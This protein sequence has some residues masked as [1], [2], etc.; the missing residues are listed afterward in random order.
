VSELLV[1]AHEDVKL[2]LAMDDCIELMAE[3]LADLARGQSWQ[4]LRFVVRPPEEQSLMGLMPA[5][6]S[7][8]K[9]AYGLKTVCIFPGNPARGLD[10]HQ[11]GVMLFDGETGELRALVDA[12]AVTSIRTAAVSAVATRALAR[13]DS[14]VLGILGSG[15]Q[16]RAHL[17]AMAR[18]LSFE[19][20]RVW[21]RTAEHA[22]AFAAEAEAPFPVEAAESAEA[23]VR[24]A[25][26][27]VTVTSAREP[28]LEHAWFAPGAHVNAVGSSIPTARELDS[29]TIAAAA[30]FVD[31]RESTLNESGEYLRAVEE[32][33]IG[34][35]HIRAELGEVL[36][37]SADGRVSPD[38][39]T[40]FVSLG[41]AVEDLAAA[42]F[43]YLRAPSE[44]AGSVVPF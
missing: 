1:L 4:P 44:G 13:P 37:G 41:L 16:A 36:I 20:A 8:P 39:L 11:G 43:V 31:R 40:V 12:S 24:D 23:A 2:L 42:E 35:D 27:V 38:E 28:I 15:V 33:G 9:P 6:R 17:E 19:Q 29:A 21:S 30:L 18:V 5:H 3:A 25:D 10:A 14:K 32:E 34:P 26:V 7:S 22:H